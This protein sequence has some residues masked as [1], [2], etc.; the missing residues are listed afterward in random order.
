MF[1]FKKGLNIL[2]KSNT[3]AVSNQSMCE[4]EKKDF[5]FKVMS[6]KS[7]QF[8]ESLTYNFLGGIHIIEL[9]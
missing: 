4:L 5:F 8:G 2:A 7:R 3:D 1:I 9:M 6:N